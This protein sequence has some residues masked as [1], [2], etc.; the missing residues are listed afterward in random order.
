M[1][2]AILITTFNRPEY[3]KE[4]LDS[5]KRSNLCGADVIVWDDNSTD[6]QV[7]EI[8]FKS[9]FKAAY[10]PQ[11]KGICYNLLTGIQTLLGW[12]YDII[13]NLDSDAIVRND[14]IERLLELH[15]RF[16]DKIITGFHSTTKNA[17]GTER[18]KMIRGGDGWCEKESVGGINMLFTKQTFEKYAKPALEKCL[19]GG[20]WD[21]QTCINAGSVI[22]TVPSVVQ[23]IGLISSLGHTHD[24]PDIAEDFVPLYLPNVSCICVDDNGQRALDTMNKCCEQVKFAETFILSNELNEQGIPKLGSK[25]AYSNFILK[26]L[27]KYIETDYALI[28]QHDGYVKNYKAWTDDF[29][30]YDYIG[31]PWWYKDEMRVGNG[32]FSLRSKK[33]LQQTAWFFEK[34]GKE[35][36]PEDHVICR[37]Y[38]KNFEAMGIKFAPVELAEKFSFEGYMQPGHWDGQFGFHGDRA[39]RRPPDPKKEGFIINQFLG[40]GDIL[41]LVPLVRK[42][43][44]DGHDIIWP[45]ADE[46]FNLKEYFSDIQFV[47]KSKFPMNYDHRNEFMHRWKYGIYRVKNL[48]WNMCKDY[49][50]AMTT[51][52]TMYGEDWR[53]WREL[54]WQRNYD[55]EKK[56]A[57]LVEAKGEYFLVANEFGNITDGGTSYKEFSFRWDHIASDHLHIINLSRIEG[58]TLLD[59]AGVIEGASE[60]HAVSSSTFYL[61]EI[62][63]LKAKEIHLY[64]RKLGQRD[65][66]YISRLM[67]KKYILHV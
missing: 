20:N 10:L 51:K 47:P 26:E 49:R 50:D 24:K 67:T 44:S 53:M 59:W 45:I 58:Y 63:N 33:L 48:R 46:Y 2:I 29:L 57:E 43:L 25:E 42:W 1:K 23:H 30:K 15:K 27:H 11:N 54:K 38:R 19:N 64:S 56:L 52:Y 37:T 12:E 16:P 21:H 34:Y 8:I 61:F 3:L 66:D 31:A 18:H 32:G 4:C 6:K 14:W 60:I 9:G 40:L 7:S 62:L 55:K 41:F 5:V 65:F 35:T 13:I 36:H 28:V 17:D 22:C 39:F